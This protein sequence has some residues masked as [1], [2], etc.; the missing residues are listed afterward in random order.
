MHIRSML[1]NCKYLIS[2]FALLVAVNTSLGFSLW[3]AAKPDATLTLSNQSKDM[4]YYEYKGENKKRDSGYLKPTD[5]KTFAGLNFPNS[6]DVHT[7]KGFFGIGISDKPEPFI[8][9]VK[10]QAEFHENLKIWMHTYVPVQEL[11][12]KD[13]KDFKAII[14][15]D[16]SIVLSKKSVYFAPL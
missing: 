5:K 11:P 16:G 12:I 6:L 1:V 14:N 15:E 8:W 3:R 7:T 10:S 13:M 9:V 2:L 4:V